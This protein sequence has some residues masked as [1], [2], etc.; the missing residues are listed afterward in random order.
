MG[1][2]ECGSYNG[3][4]LFQEK[5]PNLLSDLFGVTHAP[6][7]KNA[8]FFEAVKT[9]EKGGTWKAL[10]FSSLA[11]AVETIARNFD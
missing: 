10:G 11:A 1:V 2:E 3:T 7:D 5:A 9:L 8:I 6:D 4:T